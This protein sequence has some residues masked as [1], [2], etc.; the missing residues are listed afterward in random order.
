MWR[1][2]AKLL[3]DLIGSDQ[4]EHVF[5]PVISIRQDDGRL[6]ALRCT[7]CGYCTYLNDAG[8]DCPPCVP[9]AHK[10]VPIEVFQWDV[11]PIAGKLVQARQCALCGAYAT[12]HAEM[13]WFGCPGRR[14][15]DP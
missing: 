14:K 2:L 11:L 4:R 3:G 6:G 7:Q 12:T 15:E 1:W 13:E 5:E 8:K 9:R 10:W